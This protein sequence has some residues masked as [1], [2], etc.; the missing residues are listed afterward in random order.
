MAKTKKIKS[1]KRAVKK[2][3]VGRNKVRKIAKRKAPKALG[4]KIKVEIS[5]TGKPESVYGSELSVPKAEPIVF[6]SETAALPAQKID[7]VKVE[8]EEIKQDEVA[9]EEL[10]EE[11]FEI[12]DSDKEGTLSKKIIMYLAIGGIMIVIFMFWLLGIKNSL[13]QNLSN[14]SLGEV[15]N[16]NIPTGVIGQTINEFKA[17]FSGLK[18][19]IILQ[20]DAIS[21]LAGEIKSQAIEENLKSEI[22]N[23]LKEKLENINSINNLNSVNSNINRQNN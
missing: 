5:G 19:F 20:T 15:A 6:L 9:A 13:G 23:S 22:T 1:K 7:K 17:Q 2:Q 11:S 16:N 8:L 12:I 3:R 18:N 10:Y 21:N 4:K 14:A